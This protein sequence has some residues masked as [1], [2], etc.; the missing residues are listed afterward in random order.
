MLAEGGQYRADF[1]RHGV[2]LS[3]PAARG[4]ELP[5]LT[6]TFL[7]SARGATTELAT[8]DVDPVLTGNFV[9]YPRNSLVETYEATATGYEQ[10]FHIPYRPTGHGDLVL[11]MAVSGNVHAEAMA[12]SH[13]AIEFVHGETR[14]IRYSEAYAFDRTGTRVHVLT[15]YDGAGRLELIVPSAFLDRANYPVVVDPSV[16][17]VFNPGT[18]GWN[19][20]NPDVAYDPVTEH[21]LVVWQR[22]FSATSRAIRGQLYDKHGVTVGP[23]WFPIH[24]SS[25]PCSDPAVAWFQ[26]P[27][28]D[29]FCVVWAQSNMIRGQLVDPNN[30][31][32]IGADFNVTGNL[33]GNTDLRP[34]VS[35][36][37]TI[38]VAWDRTLN[39]NTEPTQVCLRNLSLPVVGDPSGH[40]R[41][42]RRDHRI[43][44]RRRH[45]ARHPARAERR[46]P[47]PRRRR[48]LREPRRLAALVHEPGAG[49]L[50]LSHRFVPHGS[51]QPRVPIPAAAE[52]PSGC[53]LGRPERTASVPGGARVLAP[54][55]DRPAVLHRVGGRRRRARPH[56][57]RLRPGRFADDHPRH[58]RVRRHSGSVRRVL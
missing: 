43:G 45:G 25:S 29:G 35:G 4:A 8:Q 23:G 24:W 10:T 37:G 15:R 55:P 27:G 50:G 9:R 21:Y 19:D 56:V 54:R 57:R 42:R 16:G 44:H 17:P 34:S 52:Q 32:L 2:A 36:P 31:S 18:G 26:Q 33:A 13:R 14:A 58:R 20:F 3:T 47:G 46:A 7:G 30:G 11:S 53:Q 48:L 41:H 40:D 39:G 22:N 12:A 1:D 51:R 49:R 5:N 28:T 6:L 38:T